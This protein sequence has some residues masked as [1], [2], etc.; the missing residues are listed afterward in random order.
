MNPNAY[1]IKIEK[2]KNV[3]IDKTEQEIKFKYIREVE[4]K[5][6]DKKNKKG[7]TNC[8]NV[9]YMY[10]YKYCKRII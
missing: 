5:K 7:N 3:I 1:D 2:Q 9:S 8:H 6:N 4:R 10:V